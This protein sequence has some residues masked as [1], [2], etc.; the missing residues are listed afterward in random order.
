MNV[1]IYEEKVPKERVGVVIGKKG[2]TKKMI[3]QEAGVKLKIDSK[4][5]VV[6]IEGTDPLNLFSA[7]EVVRAIARGFN[8]DVAKLL[9]KQDYVLEIINIKEFAKTKNAEIRL[10][11][12]V[13]GE[14]GRS[15]ANLERLTDCYISVYGKTVSIIGEV[16]KVQI[17]RRAVI[18]LLQGK[19]HRSVYT[20]LER[21]RREMKLAEKL[22]VDI[23]EL[24]PS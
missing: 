12:R 5:G 23:N 22:G 24:N 1:Y 20:Q 2:E 3:E 6:K 11:G 17:A 10:K 16:E 18:G 8:P 4:E 13:I 19:T 14:E 21:K 15:R 9:L 7:R